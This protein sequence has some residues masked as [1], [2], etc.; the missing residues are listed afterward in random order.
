VTESVGILAHLTTVDTFIGT[1]MPDGLALSLGSFWDPS[2]GNLRSMALTGINAGTPTTI[3]ERYGWDSTMY[4]N[5]TPTY[6]ISVAETVD[7]YMYISYV[8][9]TGA[10]RFSFNSF[11]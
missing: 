1:V 8:A 6:P 10:L 5:E 9:S 3:T 4:L 7:A 2:Y 11:D